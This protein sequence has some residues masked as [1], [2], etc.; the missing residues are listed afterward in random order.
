MDNHTGDH[1]LSNILAEGKD[2]YYASYDIS[3]HIAIFIFSLPQETSE[4]FNEN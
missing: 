4:P 2:S 1:L 3:M